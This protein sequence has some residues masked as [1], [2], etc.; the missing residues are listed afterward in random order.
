M[1]TTNAN[2]TVSVGPNHHDATTSGN[3][4]QLKSVGVLFVPNMLFTT[5]WHIV[6]QE[7][8]GERATTRRAVATKAGT[9]YR[10]SCYLYSYMI[11]GPKYKTFEPARSHAFKT[12][13]KYDRDAERMALARFCGVAVGDKIELAVLPSHL[14]GSKA[15]HAAHTLCAASFAVSPLHFDAH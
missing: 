3:K 14:Q 10:S 15:R 2:T 1:S 9:T 4:A 5:V 13:N 11:P 7:E 8:Q 12:L 6:P